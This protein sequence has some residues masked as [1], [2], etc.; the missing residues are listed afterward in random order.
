MPIL[1]ALAGGNALLHAAGMRR[2][3]AVQLVAAVTLQ[4]EAGDFFAYRPCRQIHAA[5]GHR[6]HLRHQGAHLALERPHP[7]L[8]PAHAVDQH[9]I[10]PQRPFA[11][12]HP[13]RLGRRTLE[14]E[15][16]WLQGQV[17]AAAGLAG[18]RQ[19]LRVQRQAQAHGQQTQRQEGKRQPWTHRMR[20]AGKFCGP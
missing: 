13:G 14:H 5:F 11:H 3:A 10:N 12:H 19:V 7:L 1:G 4:A 6:A 2:Q 9:A 17:V 18:C 15:L 8:L 16:P 20:S